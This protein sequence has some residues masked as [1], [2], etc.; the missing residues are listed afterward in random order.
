MEKTEVRTK[1]APAAAGP[2]SQAIRTGGF[3]F[4][5]GQLPLDPDTNKMVQGAFGDK[6]K[7]C[8]ENIGA[9]LNE[10]GADFSNL[11]KVTIYSTDMMEFG[12]INNA[13]AKFFDSAPPA[14]AVVG[15]AKLP[16]NADVE[17]EAVAGL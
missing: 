15:V 1:N 13:Y 14:R 12:N 10:A 8:M 5:S 17:I 11:V 2:Y 9:I 16:L 3:L 7:R 6:T 4:I